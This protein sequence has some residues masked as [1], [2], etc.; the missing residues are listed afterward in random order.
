MR[1]I[2]SL[3]VSTRRCGVV[4]VKILGVPFLLNNVCFLYSLLITITFYFKIV[5]VWHD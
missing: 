5:P 3:G 2:R 4:F 1:F